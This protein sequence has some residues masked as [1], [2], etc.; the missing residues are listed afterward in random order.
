MTLS[1]YFFRQ[2]LPPFL[3]GVFIFLSVFVLDKLFELIDLIFNKGVPLLVVLKIF[4]LFLPTIFPLIVPMA[5]LLACM[6]TFGRI[7]EENELTAVRAGGVSLSKVFWLPVLFTLV[8]SWTLVPFNTFVAPQ[9]NQTFRTILQEILNKDPLVNVEPK[10]FFSVRNMKIFA[11]TVDTNS[12]TLKNVF[13]F[14]SPPNKGPMDRYFARE[15][16]IESNNET[17]SLFL[18]QGQ[19]ERYDLKNPKILFHTMFGFYKIQ[20]PLNL[21]KES[22]TIRF[23]NIT[24]SELKKLIK[25]F[26]SQ[27]LPVSQLEA[28]DSL[29]YAIAFAPIALAVVGIPLALNFKK[30]SKA[31]GFG[32]TFLIVFIY[33]LILISGLTLAEKTLLAPDL[34]LWL[35]NIICFV[36]GGFLLY[37]MGKK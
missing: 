27:H 31:F 13:V 20:V 3:F 33:Y 10:K 30:G 19:V 34:S 15:G 16:T 32:V 8:L 28:E 35:G 23:R 37:R 11:E 21:A 9:A 17:F 1:L 4:S 29:R 36:I 7:S 26:K 12:K 25:Q 2:F 5:I 18:R 6:V 22:Q 24:T 14:Q